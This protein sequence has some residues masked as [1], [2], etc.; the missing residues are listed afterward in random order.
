MN[1]IHIKSY[2]DIFEETK[3]WGRESKEF[4]INNRT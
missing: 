2:N 1:N 4:T 3:K